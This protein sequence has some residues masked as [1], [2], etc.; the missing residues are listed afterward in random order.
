M[1]TSAFLHHLTAQPSYSGQ[2]AHVEHIPP[3]DA[4]CVE[5]DKPLVSSLQDCLNEHGLLPLYVH[6]AEAIN[7]ARQGKNV[8]V[9]TSSAS[10]KTLCYNIPVLEALLTERFSRALYLFPTKALAQGQ[11]RGLLE[12]FCPSL[13]KVEELA[14]F[15]GDTP[16]PEQPEIRKRARVILTNPDMLHIGILPNHQSWSRLLKQ[17]KYVVVDEAHIYRGVFGSHVACV[18][19]RLRRLCQLYGSS[20]QFICCS[21]TI[22]N[23]GEHAERLV[24]LPFEVVSSDGSPH[25]GKEFVFWNPP[26][27]DEVRSVRRSAN[28]EAT[29]LFTELV[30]RNIRS[31]TFAHTR[32]LT[33]LIYAYSRRRLAEVSSA[34]AKQIKAY[35]A[36]YL[37]QERRKI[38]QELF[39]G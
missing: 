15:D 4:N 14:T 5:L 18:L 26:I 9:A 34:L 1:D 38:E 12:L 30:S 28:S 32:R 37:P 16:Q 21:A 36:G 24:G 35:R 7:Y 6:Q 20:P 23:S 13:F 2:I 29:N 39:S 19:R 33:E 27:I 22:A 8:M 17:L 25:G 3:R 31:L 11:L 10:G